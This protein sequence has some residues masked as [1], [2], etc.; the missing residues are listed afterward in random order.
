MTEGCLPGDWR[1]LSGDPSPRGYTGLQGVGIADLLVPAGK[2]LQLIRWAGAPDR[3]E[4]LQVLVGASPKSTATQAAALTD[5]AVKL[6]ARWAIGPALYKADVDT[7]GAF[8]IVCSTVDVFLAN[9][10]AS[11]VRVCASIVAGVSGAPPARRTVLAEPLAGAKVTAAIPTHGRAVTVIGNL[12]A[13]GSF[14]VSFV[15]AAGAMIASISIT[16]TTAG[17][18]PTLPIPVGSAGVELTNPAAGPVPVA[19]VFDLG[20]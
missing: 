2:T 19:F 9:E 6:Q 8:G 1:S 7:L 18:W 17:P 13:A 10:S 12:V 20:T 15:D 3:P 5:R 4:R 14:L 11:D 16:P